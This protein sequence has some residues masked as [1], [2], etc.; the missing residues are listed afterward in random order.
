LL[1]I[2]NSESDNIYWDCNGSIL[3]NEVLP[4]RIAISNP[5]HDSNSF[6]HSVNILTIIGI[7]P[8]YYS[9]HHNQVEVGIMY[10]LPWFL[11]KG[12]SNCCNCKTCYT[13]NHIYICLASGLFSVIPRNFVLQILDIFLFSWVIYKS[14]KEFFLVTNCIKCVMSIFSVNKLVLN[15]LLTF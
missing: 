15:K 8:K 11:G 4:T 3:I 6:F 1:W 5:H 10:H 13:H 14:L 7:S 12:R 2:T 9:I